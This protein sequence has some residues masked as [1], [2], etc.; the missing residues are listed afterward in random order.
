[1]RC[2]LLFSSKFELYRSFSVLSRG[3]GVCASDSGAVDV[4]VALLWC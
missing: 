3:G 1:M 2:F 4:V